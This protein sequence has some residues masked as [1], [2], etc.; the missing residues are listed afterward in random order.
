[1]S[2]KDVIDLQ[3]AV[4][5]LESADRMAPLL[6]AAGYPVVPGITADTPKASHPDS[7]DWEKRFH[8][9]ADPGRP[10]NLH[11]RVAGSPGWR[12]ALMFRDWLIADREARNLYG[13]RKVQLADAH[14]DDGNTAG[15][16]DAKEPWFTAVAWPR[17]EEWAARTGWAP[18]SY[19]P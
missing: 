16:A 5:D 9:N 14:A 17:M 8:A 4:K 19:S 2:A 6:A 10:V 13:A 12:Y 15:Y 11:V 18:P 1:L 7:A 3:L